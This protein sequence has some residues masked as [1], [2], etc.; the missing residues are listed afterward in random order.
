MT[1]S[2]TVDGV[3]CETRDQSHILK[4][5][6]EQLLSSTGNAVNYLNISVKA[7]N[8]LNSSYGCYHYNAPLTT[9]PCSEG[10]SGGVLQKPIQLSSAQI[11]NFKHII[12]NNAREIQSLHGGRIVMRK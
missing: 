12:S 7:S 6:R 5:F 1:T 8:V 10:V 4:N 9:P 2:L 11:N 3:M